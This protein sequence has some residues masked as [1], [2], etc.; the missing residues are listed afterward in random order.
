MLFSTP[1]ES[2][3][4]YKSLRGIFKVIWSKYKIFSNLND[5]LLFTVPMKEF[6]AHYRIELL[7]CVGLKG[8]I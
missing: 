3:S 6:P 4:A 7:C 2:K 8:K 1:F 5:L